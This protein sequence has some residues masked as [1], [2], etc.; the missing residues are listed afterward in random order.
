MDPHRRIR[1]YVGFQS[2]SIL[3]YLEPLTGDLFRARFTDCI[4]NVGHFLALGGDNKFITNGR[5]INW[6]DKSILSSDPRTKEIELQVQKIIELQQIASNLPNVFIDYKCITK[7]L[8]STVNVPCRVEVP[9]K[10]TPP[11]KRGRASQQKDA[12]NKRPK[13]TRKTSSSKKVNASQPKVDG[14]QVD[15]INSLP[16]PHVRTTE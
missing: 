14:H 7:F 2:S 5:E 16:S 15:M 6:D 3:K 11:P 10:T 1:I 9:I 8:N 12:S 4:F 13:N